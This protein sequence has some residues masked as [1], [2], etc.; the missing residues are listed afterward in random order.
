[1][2]NSGTDDIQLRRSRLRPARPAG[3]PSAMVM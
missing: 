3:D 1:M 2:T